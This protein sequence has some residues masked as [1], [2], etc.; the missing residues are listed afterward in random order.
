[1]T[2][3]SKI[4]AVAVASLFATG[5]FAASHG[6]ALDADGDGMLTEEEFAPIA[7]MGAQF[8]AYD[9]DGDG[10]VS[11]AEYNEG[12]RSLANPDDGEETEEVLAKRDELARMFS[13]V[14]ADGDPDTTN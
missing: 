13:G 2:I 9:S 12:I 11:E 1:M 8:V 3:K 14:E 10:M 7:E 5:A 4:T 6:G